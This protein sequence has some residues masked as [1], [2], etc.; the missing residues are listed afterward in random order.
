[1]HDS[2]REVVIDIS[3]S[4]PSVSGT[5]GEVGGGRSPAVGAGW[6]IVVAK[7]SL[8]PADPEESAI[9]ATTLS[10]LRGMLDMDGR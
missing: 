9:Q 1:M 10:R 8:D 2:C 6:L 3:M 5:V 7:V 4:T